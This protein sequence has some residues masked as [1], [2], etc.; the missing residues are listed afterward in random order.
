M[1]NV[2]QEGHKGN[3]ENYRLIS[4][5]SIL[6]NIIKQILLKTNSSHKKGK[7]VI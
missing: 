1:A 7:R 3:P 4:L 5:T 2:I 6:G